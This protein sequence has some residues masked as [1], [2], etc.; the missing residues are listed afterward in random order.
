MDVGNLVADESVVCE[1]NLYVFL[2]HV[3]WEHLIEY[4]SAASTTASESEDA[5]K[6]SGAP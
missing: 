1:E 5:Q 2:R 4:A 6:C 3:E